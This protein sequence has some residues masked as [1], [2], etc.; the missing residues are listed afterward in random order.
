MRRVPL[1][2][3]LVV[4]LALAM[5]VAL[6]LWQIRRA[7]WKDA[8]LASYQASRNAPDLYGIPPGL[9]PDGVAFRHAHVL[10]RVTTTATVIGGTDA[11]GRTGFRNIVGCALIDGRTIMADLGLSAIDAK[12]VLP[13]IGQPIQGRGLLVPDDVLAKRMFGE[14]PV[15]PLLLVLD[16]GMPGLSASKPPSIETIPNNHISY[17]VQ[18]F[19]FAAVALIIY[20]IALWKRNTG[21]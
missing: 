14:T 20:G 6:G 10:C 7:H 12:P 2:P 16:G 8:L 5:M 3:T 4:A 18:W 13:A 19:L 11:S 17:A 21:R 15:V 1:L 9:Q